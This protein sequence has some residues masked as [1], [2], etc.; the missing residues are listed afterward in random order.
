M[1]VE[2]ITQANAIYNEIQHLKGNGYLFVKDYKLLSETMQE[3]S[4]FSEKG[5]LKIYT[6]EDPA[7]FD[8]LKN[9]LEQMEQKKQSRIQELEKQFAE[10]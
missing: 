2:K 1:T 3:V 5:S 6:S 10:L 9:H 4:I 8:L 7:L